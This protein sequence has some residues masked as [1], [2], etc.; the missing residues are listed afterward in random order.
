MSHGRSASDDALSRAALASAP[1]GIFVVDREG[2]FVLANEQTEQLFGYAPGELLGLHFNGLLPELF[3]EEHQR[4]LSGYT[5]TPGIQPGR[6]G[7]ELRGLRKDGTEILLEMSLCAMNAPEEPLVCCIFR[8]IG[9][10]RLADQSAREMEERFRFMVENSH[11]I[12]TIRDA[13][14][15]VRYTNPSVHRVLGYK[16]EE[17]IGSTGF[18]LI[19]PDDRSAVEDAFHEFWKNP[20]ARDSIQ[21]R[22]RH[23]NGTWIS[24]EVTAY[25]LLD[26][27]VI[28]GV[29]IN[30]RDISRRKQEESGNEQL[31]AELQRTLA[32]AKTLTGVLPICASCKKI[33]EG[34]RWHQVEA[35]IR[36]RSQVE[37]SHTMCPECTTLWYP[38]L[39][40]S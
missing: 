39:Q 35:Y 33:Q 13:D 6:S 27:P 25:N 1:E 26:H 32:N 5:R 29:V 30:G 31:I 4:Q 15:R 7:L 10:P 19:H 34:D 18:E 40:S 16:Q 22:A 28:Q 14:G 21:Y 38:G 11:D 8:K 9:S 36:D 3:R 12:V 23:A 24:I 17:M 2:R 37:F 20:G